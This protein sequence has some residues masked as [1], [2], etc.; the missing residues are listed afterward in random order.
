[1]GEA[2]VLPDATIDPSSDLGRQL[3]VDLARYREGLV[4]EKAIRKKFRLDN[5]V[6]QA[7][8]D[9]DELIRA[10]EAEAVRRIADG[11]VKRERAQVL[12]ARAP[13]VLGDILNDASQS[14]RHR[15]DSAKTLNDFASNGPERPPPAIGPLYY[16]DKLSGGD[17]VLHFNKI[18]QT[19][20]RRHRS[21]QP[22][23]PTSPP[24][25]GG[26]LQQSRRRKRTATMAAKD[27]FERL[28]EGRPPQEPTPPP[29]PL[30]TPP[31]VRILLDWLQHTW[32]KPTICTRDIYRYRPNVAQDRERALESAEILVKRGWLIPLKAHRHDRKRW[33]IT[34]GPV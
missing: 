2:V 14:A 22:E 4:D 5:D 24:H 1:M 29:T 27:I 18:D 8:G 33:Q 3:V 13:T 15:I 26:C 31:E 21:L 7:L 16:Y 25:R 28:K 30:P 10:V 19:R 32:T 23:T 11:S 17:H 34:I 12:V 9:D 6:W 20:R